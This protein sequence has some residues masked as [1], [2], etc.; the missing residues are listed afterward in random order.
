MKINKVISSKSFEKTLNTYIKKDKSFSQEFKSF[1]KE[2]IENP[3]NEKFKLHKL[4]WKLDWYYS[5]KIKYDLRLILNIKNDIVIL[6]D[7]GTHDNVY[8]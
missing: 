5:V 7:I 4:K 8:R 2:F 1:F 6:Y 3:T